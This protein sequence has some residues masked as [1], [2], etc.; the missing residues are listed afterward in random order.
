MSVRGFKRSEEQTG[1]SDSVGG[2]VVTRRVLVVGAVLS[3][4]MA[5]V[6]LAVGADPVPTFQFTRSGEFREQ[7]IAVVPS[8]RNGFLTVGWRQVSASDT[9]MWVTNN[10]ADGSLVWERTIGVESA[11]EGGYSVVQSAGLFA[12]AGQSSSNDPARRGIVVLRLN[13]RGELASSRLLV[14]GEADGDFG[15][16]AIA[17]VP[18]SADVI[19][20]GRGGLVDGSN[21]QRMVLARVSMSGQVVWAFFYNDARHIVGFSGFSDLEVTSA[22][23]GPAVITAVGYTGEFASP[24]QVLLT[25]VNA[26]TGD[27]LLSRVLTPTSISA[28]GNGVA[29]REDGS[30][31][32][33]ARVAA[34]T[35][36]DSLLILTNP[37]FEPQTTRLFGRLSFADRSIHATDSGFAVA[38][39]SAAFRN[40]STLTFVAP[41]GEVAGS[42]G[43]GGPNEEFCLG[44][45]PAPLGGYLLV[46]YTTGFEASIRDAY[47]IK[48]DAAGRSPCNLVTSP[49]LDSPFTAISESITLTRTP[50][51]NSPIGFFVSGETTSRTLLCLDC[52]A[53]FNNNQSV[54]FFDY[55]DFVAAF[56][57]EEPSADFNGDGMIDLFDYLDFVL[58]LDRGC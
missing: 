8:E 15:G 1:G 9:N 25:R 21:R 6:P 49:T 43:F 5:G 37:R 38:G 55:L 34:P 4:S 16:T 52:P 48:T 20:A 42:F 32:I 40:T 19:V 33:T 56:A 46:G 23:D 51:E 2:F 41:D 31:A 13:P 53:D 26:E 45:T 3:A 18:S 50:L 11:I 35:P 7:I 58:A 12:I 39:T 47:V 28:V 10:A 44:M 57:A 54:D 22:A 17:R 14:T 27:V 30:L 24:R 29:I 36:S